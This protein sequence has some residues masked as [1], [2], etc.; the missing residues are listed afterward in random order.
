MVRRD[1]CDFAG[2]C[3]FEF[4]RLVFRGNTDPLSAL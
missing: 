2:S 4:E 1:C 3:L